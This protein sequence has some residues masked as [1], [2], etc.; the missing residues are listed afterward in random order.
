MLPGRVDKGGDILTLNGGK[1]M[2]KM[3]DLQHSPVTSSQHKDAMSVIE[4]NIRN[5]I[6]SSIERILD[7]EIENAKQLLEK[8]LKEK[9][10][11]I[12]IS[13]AQ[14]AEVHTMRDRIVVEFNTK[15]IQYGNKKCQNT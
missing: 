5:A 2:S 13:I 11:E 15:S 1:F 10:A 7:E 3:S 12:S 8:R 4:Q 9:A 6:H 14:W